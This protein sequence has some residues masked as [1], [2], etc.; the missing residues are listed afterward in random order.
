MDYKSFYLKIKYLIKKIIH[1]PLDI[2]K[3]KFERKFSR[4]YFLSDNAGWAADRTTKSIFLMTKENNF[5]CSQTINHPRNQYVFYGD[6]YS[7]FSKNVFNYNNV[8]SFDYEHG[9]PQYSKVNK[10]LLELVIRN[11]KK[12]SLIRVTN[13]FFKNFLVKN[14]LS[15]NKIRQ[16]PLT[17]NKIFK[18]FD[19]K[20]KMYYKNLYNL[21]KDRF[22]IGSF[23][24]DGDG[25]G[26]GMSPKYLK[27]PEIFLKSLE[28]MKDKDKLFVLL[29]GPARGFMKK[30]LDKLGVQYKHFNLDKFDQLP[31]LYNC[32][33]L[34][35]ISSR[36]E[37]GPTGLGEAMACGIPIVSTKVGLAYDFITHNKNGYLANLDDYKMIAKY[38]QN[39]YED[40]QLCEKFS[41]NSLEIISD[42]FKDQ[43]SHLWKSFFDDLKTKNL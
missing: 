34:Y 31:N 11:Q 20:K 32:L 12:I 22:I 28:L 13:S 36:D 21:P 10:E 16:I 26:D 3:F 5:D 41:R 43:H 17:V 37:G 25:F 14:G 23:H 40:P 30:G 2:I 15:V 38:I 9:L 19:D 35:L 42:H 39:L 24:K 27:A 6:Q 29:T 7:L 8:I 4:I 18:K 1:L 33:N